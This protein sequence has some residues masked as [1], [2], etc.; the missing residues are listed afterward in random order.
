MSF[1]V[2][3]SLDEARLLLALA[4]AAYIDEKP[5]PGETVQAQTARMR[6]DIDT[7]LS[8]SAYAGW[9]VAW[10][11]GLTD[12]RSNMMYVAGNI[13]TNQYAVAI[14][15]TDWSFWLDWIED[16][17]SLLPLILF[18]FQLAPIDQNVK[19]AAGTLF[20]LEELRGMSGLGNI[21]NA[22]PMSMQTFLQSLP[23][24]ASIFVT[25]HSLGGCLA[26]VTAAWLA[27]VFLG[28]S[29][30]KTYTFAGPSAGN[31]QFADYYNTIFTDATSRKS[32]AYRV[33]NTLDAIPNAWATLPTIE[34]YYQ[35]KPHCPTY[36]KD[37][38]DEAQA[39]IGTE[40][41]QVG[42]TAH[43]SA[44]SLKGHVEP[45]NSWWDLDPTGTAQFAH[46]VGIQHGT[47]TYLGLLS[48]VP[49]F[50]STMK[51]M[52]IG[53]RVRAR[54]AAAAPPTS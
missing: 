4:T 16:F 15:G 11:P 2:G 33:F 39:H 32:T 23:A 45:W 46:Q 30:L 31:R 52:A 54:R 47:A 19:V 27:F 34:T 38:I 22:P 10:G 12:D 53:A 1:T 51:L 3:Y 36:I 44:V 21:E 42:S 18:P 24:N 43:G 8:E 25:G 7:S 17:A 48:A 9:Q 37:I 49:A 28:A 13:V 14:R 29:R 41:T 6:K 50:A 20:G 35:P 5:L 26:S 40:Y